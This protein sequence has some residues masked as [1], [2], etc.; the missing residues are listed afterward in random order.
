MCR[1]ESYCLQRGRRP[2][3]FWPRNWLILFVLTLLLLPGAS[4][5]AIGQENVYF[6]NEGFEG[7]GFENSGWIKHGAPNEDY[8][9]AVLHGA[10]S[11]YCSNAA[12]IS[13]SFQMTDRF[14][15]YFRVR[16]NAWGDFNNVIFWY[17]SAFIITARITVNPLNGIVTLHHGSVTA[18]STAPVRLNTTYHMWVEWTKGI[19]I[20]G[21]LLLYFSTDGKKPALPN[22]SIIT[23]NG[24]AIDSINIGPTTPGQRVVYDRILAS[25]LPIG[26]SPAPTISGIPDQILAQNTFSAA[27]PFVVTEFDTAAETLAVSGFSSNPA[28]V[29]N[30]NIFLGGS[31]SNR[32]VMV[33]PAASQSGTALISIVVSDGSLTGTNSFLTTVTPSSKPIL[34]V[35]ANSATRAYGAANPE[36]T[37]SI[38]GLQDGDDITASYAT[39]ANESSSV[40][41]YPIRVALNDPGA[42]LSNYTVTTNEGTLTI[43][44]SPLAIT[45]DNQARLYGAPNPPLTGSIG[46]LQ[47]SDNIS[48]SYTT[49]AAASSPIGTYEISATL[50]DPDA[51][52]PNYDVTVHAGTLSVLPAG[53][54]TI[55]IVESNARLSGTGAPGVSYAIQ[56]TTDLVDWQ[57]IG[58]A[59]A[60]TNGVL[61]FEDRDI[62]NF[63]IRF[64][65]AIA[66]P[67]LLI[68]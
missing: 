14:N 54:R 32:T 49:V 53:L 24:R 50:N 55:Q 7:P 3:F 23:G 68:R 16:W 41:N 65:R 63:N 8:T 26:D 45:A 38:A 51:K 25:D 18:Q 15:V 19:G 61:E 60:N 22:A 44:P 59:T 21:T 29:P 13:H 11:L 66:S 62:P 12:F 64:Y 35:T 46:G 43:S 1:R 48:C 2:R 39:S 33:V 56:A 36:L 57:N 67:G 20:D 17:D 6:P 37:G 58:T 9:D 47:N 40:G 28:L 52:L 27:V 4:F 42:R 5:S 30:E 34:T 10:Q 31:G